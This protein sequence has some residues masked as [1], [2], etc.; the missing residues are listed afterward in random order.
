MLGLPLV[1]HYPLDP[2]VARAST[3]ADRFGNWADTSAGTVPARPSNLPE[4]AATPDAATLAPEEVRRLT[5]VNES[6]AG[7]AFRS[8]SAPVPYLPSTEFNDRFGN[9]SMPTADG[10]RPEPSRLI[11]PFANEP[12]YFIPPPIFG[13]DGAGSPHNDA[14]EWYARWIRPLRGPE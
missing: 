8:G 3:F 9:W 5:R 7:S 14:E 11:G 10:R 1:G 4:G 6:N 12:S 13:V 2:D